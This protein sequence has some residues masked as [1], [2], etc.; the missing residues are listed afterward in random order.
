MKNYFYTLLQ[1]FISTA[2]C[3]FSTQTQAQD[4]LKIT[5]ATDVTL[6]DKE[7]YIDG[8]AS[9]YGC[10]PYGQTYTAQ[11]TDPY[12]AGPAPLA[13]LNGNVGVCVRGTYW[14][15]DKAKN[16]Q[17]AGGV[18][19]IQIA[20]DRPVQNILTG[21]NAEVNIWGI[22]LA[23]EF[24]PMFANNPG[25]QF[26]FIHKAAPNG[27]TVIWG[28]NNDEGNFNGG[29]NG[30]KNISYECGGVES[31]NA[32]WKWNYQ[33]TDN[34]FGTAMHSE[35]AC[36]GAVVFDSGL[37]NL[38][39]SCFTRNKGALESPNITIP[40]GLAGISLRWTQRVGHYDSKY[41]VGWSTDDGAT[42][43]SIQINQEVPQLNAVDNGL[44][45][46][47][48]FTRNLR[49]PNVQNAETVKIR[50]IID[51]NYYF[52]GIDDVMLI[53]PENNN[54]ALPISTN[55]FA[56]PT[57]VQNFHTQATTNVWMTDVENIG[58]LTASNVVLTVSV[59]DT[60]TKEVIYSY[61]HQIGDINS[62]DTLQNIV[63]QDLTFETPDKP[64]IYEIK[65]QISMDSTDYDLN[66][67]SKTMLWSISADRYG[68][69]LNYSD[70]WGLTG[71]GGINWLA[72]AI[73]KQE[74]D[75]AFGTFDHVKVGF[76]NQQAAFI[77]MGAEVRVYEY[78]D[79]NGDQQ[80]SNAEY[81]GGN[82][83]PI[84]VADITIDSLN[85]YQSMDIELHDIDTYEPTTV[86]MKAGKSYIVGIRF[87][88][89]INTE[90]IFYMVDRSYNSYATEFAQQKFKPELYRPSS[91]FQRR[92]DDK[93]LNI[94]ID[95]NRLGLAMGDILVKTGV[96]NKKPV[97]ASRSMSVFPT[98]AKDYINV[99]FNMQSSTEGQLEVLDISGKRIYST[100]ADNYYDQ[101]IRIN[102]GQIIPGTYFVRLTTNQGTISK[103][104]TVIK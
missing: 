47:K 53:V 79:V 92:D 4:Y 80:I 62:G 16:I 37:M 98:I 28:L 70:A 44:D 66:D 101:T 34:Y 6:I 35:T 7:I 18:G 60:T 75:D 19:M 15:I 20:D 65:Y 73:F 50:F 86:E 27:F 46:I 31:S 10:L 77:G 11:V 8:L 76:Y 56:G 21:E 40:P 41:Y 63:N 24:G 38:D 45:R 1:L 36:N 83:V 91:I 97:L 26:E 87:L 95:R 33:G 103:Q 30:W 68:A 43:D 29:F 5:S 74:N 39:S 2:L 22:S 49:L 54:I 55:W 90:A 59:T 12:V 88:N 14:Y 69:G 93:D 61:D 9:W 102:L 48:E 3:V 13:P 32:T 96:K 64:G 85:A 23:A 94:T 89:E 58:A 104:F 99:E 17:D 67:N 100:K 25:L 52:W 82:G 42:W 51:G 84:A 71:E 78:E 81:T 72:G 57:M